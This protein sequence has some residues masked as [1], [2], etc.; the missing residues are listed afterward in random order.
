MAKGTCSI[1]GEPE[2]ARGWCIKH[3]ARWRKHGDPLGVGTLGRPKGP[4][5]KCKIL[6]CPTQVCARGWCEKHYR[7][8]QKSGDPLVTDRILG[9]IEARFW[10]K[11]DRRGDDECWLWTGAPGDNGYGMFG[12]GQDLARAHV[13]AYERFVGPIPEDQPFINH[14]C[15]TRATSCPGGVC[16]HRRCVNFLQIPGRSHLEPS[17]NRENCLAG[18]KTKLSDEVVI[19]LHARHLAGE[20]VD[21]LALETGTHRANL[22]KR[23]RRI[24]VTGQPQELPGLFDAAS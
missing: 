16:I 14:A 20:T 7:R 23:F 3:Y 12:I 13:W 22:Y 9:D 5:I 19:G 6:A 11:V 15:H 17:T 2:L 24:A 21:A 1:C 10:S 18:R 4:F 8:W